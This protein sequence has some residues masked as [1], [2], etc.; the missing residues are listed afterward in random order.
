MYSSM[1]GEFA[2]Y[3]FVTVAVEHRDGS[4]PRTF[5]NHPKQGEGS[6]GGREEKGGA[7]NLSQQASKRFDRIDYVFP[8]GNPHDTSPNNEKGVDRE[9]RDA[10][11][12]L[13]SAE[14]SEAYDVVCRIVRGEGGAVA[15]QNL[16]GKGFRGGSKS[17]R[18]F[19]SSTVLELTLR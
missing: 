16:R 8:L 14:I 3:G 17:H 11:I 7:Q 19:C 18:Q 2:S 12:D 13:R 1:C 9:L 6:H 10:Q 15:R 4:G 5:V